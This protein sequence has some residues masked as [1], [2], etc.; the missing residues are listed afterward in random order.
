MSKLEINAKQHD[1]AL[2]SLRDL[3]P[4]VCDQALQ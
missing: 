3:Q 2:E 1:P 4:N